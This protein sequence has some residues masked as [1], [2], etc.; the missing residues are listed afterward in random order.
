MPSHTWKRM[1]LE[2]PAIYRTL[3]ILFVNLIVISGCATLKYPPPPSP[4]VHF[5][6]PATSGALAEVS[7]RFAETHTAEQSGFLLLTPN[8]VAYKWRLALIDHATKS[9]DVQY[10][11]WQR[12]ESGILLFDRL[13]KAADRGVRVRLLVDD[14]LFAAKDRNIANIT[15]H[16]NFDIKI[17]NPGRIRDSTLGKMGILLLFSEN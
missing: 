16:P 17:F 2:K 5:L 1:K 4:E 9:I 3:K 7:T 11:I 8:D 15:R 6:A 12:D 10:F 14:L 13:L